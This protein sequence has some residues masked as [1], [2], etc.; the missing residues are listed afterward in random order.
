[1]AEKKGKKRKIRLRGLIAVLLVIYL[2]G[3][4]I[5]Y[6]WKMPIKSINI[7]GNYHLKDNYIINYLDLE[8]ESIFKVNKKNLKNKLMKIDLISDVSVNKNI[9]GK[10]EIKI[11][12]DKILFYD[13]NIKKIV[14]SS[15][16][17]T[18]Y[19]KEYLGIPSLIN[20]V[21]DEIYKEFIDKL[22]LID[23]ETLSL[24]SEIEY[25]RSM[26]NEK[27]VDD[28]RFLFRM[29]DGNIVYIN[30]LNIEKFND[31]LDIYEVIV[32]KNGNV[33]GCLYLDS[34]SE[35]NHF[36]NCESMEAVEGTIDNGES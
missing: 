8:N 19:S 27:V 33:T 2:A 29:N 12:E 30:T 26:V 24:V 25:S 35:N 6:L 32:N 1:M 7:E 20:Y 28:K 4:C 14:L 23:K 10:L 17:T 13:W 21:P 9:F 5:Y 3:T 16:K 36:N 31:Y 34:N 15:G 11:V 22:N 18:E